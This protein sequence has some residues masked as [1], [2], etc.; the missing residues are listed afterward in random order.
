MRI[1]DWSSDVCSSDLIDE[2]QERHRNLMTQR[3]GIQPGVL[4]TKP[5]QAGNTAFVHP[6][7]VRGT[8]RE[9]VNV[10]RSITDP[11][12]RALVVHFLLVDVHP[13]NDGYGR[14]S[15]IMMTKEIQTG[16]ESC[17]EKRCQTG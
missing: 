16:R 13:F 15:R 9:G 14:I 6:D 2:V 12:S 4:K 3:P 11:F 1:S 7:L 8:L 10:L 17:R 5:N